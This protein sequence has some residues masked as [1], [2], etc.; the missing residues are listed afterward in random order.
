ML[1]VSQRIAHLILA[2]TLKVGTVIFIYAEEETETLRAYVTAHDFRG[3]AGTQV[4][5]GPESLIY[6][7]P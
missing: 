5:L 3:R 1:C 4:C 2:V 6:T 7:V